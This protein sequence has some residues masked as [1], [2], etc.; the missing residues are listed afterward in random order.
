MERR[1]PAPLATSLRRFGVD[2]PEG[3]DVTDVAE[4]LGMTANAV[5]GAKRRVLRRI[6]ELKP[7]MEDAW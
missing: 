7:F 4:Q 1:G 5:Y 3:R 6:R 2:V